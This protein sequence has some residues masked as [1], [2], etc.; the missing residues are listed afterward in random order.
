M[1]WIESNA[2]H[3]VVFPF[4]QVELIEKKLPWINYQK[5]FDFWKD[6]KNKLQNTQN[7]LEQRKKEYE[8]SQVPLR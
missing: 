8:D 1:S 3:K 7:S 6:A 5:A 4:S 2:D